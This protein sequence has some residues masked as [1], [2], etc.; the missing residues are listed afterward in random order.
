MIELP[1]SIV[2]WLAVVIVQAVIHFVVLGARRERLQKEEEVVFETLSLSTSESFTDFD[3]TTTSVAD[4]PTPN[5]RFENQVAVA[6]AAAA[7]S[8][9]LLEMVNEEDEILLLDKTAA[10]NVSD[11]LINSPF[12]SAAILV[13]DNDVDLIVEPSPYYLMQTGKDILRVRYGDQSPL[14]DGLLKDPRHCV[15]TNPELSFF[16]VVSFLLILVELLARECRGRA[17]TSIASMNLYR[18]SMEAIAHE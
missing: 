9:S 4:Q 11:P 15:L 5:S 3:A 18:F 12:S 16:N 6:V 7:S 14:P 13:D 2:A 10:V 8:S 1:M 17:N